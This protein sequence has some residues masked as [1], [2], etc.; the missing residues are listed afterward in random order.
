L[1]EAL[2][3][4]EGREMFEEA[5]KDRLNDGDDERSRHPF[6]WLKGGMSE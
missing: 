3:T 1:P 4:E 5:L 6:S 2:S